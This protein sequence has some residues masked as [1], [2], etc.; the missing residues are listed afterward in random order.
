MGRVECIR[1]LLEAGA[2]VNGKSTGQVGLWSNEWSALHGASAHG[3]VEAVRLLLLHG[4]TTESRSE[5]QLTPLMEASR[6]REGNCARALLE[7]GADVA[8][9][10][11]R[12]FTALHHAA[13]WCNVPVVVLLLSYGADPA[14][15]SN[16]G[17]TP[18]EHCQRWWGQFPI[19]TRVVGITHDQSC[20]VVEALEGTQLLPNGRWRARRI[21]MLLWARHSRGRLITTKHLEEQPDSPENHLGRLVF[22]VILTS[23]YAE[24][25]FR[26]VVRFL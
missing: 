13:Q 15:Q 18:S 12:G 6:T 16:R 9:R 21:I 14:A 20:D 7:A 8:A 2:S 10:D 5:L 24:H 25:L 4:A 1:I 22:Q 19:L 17:A 23:E 26:M 11:G 3:C